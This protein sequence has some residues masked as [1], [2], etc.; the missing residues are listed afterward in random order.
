MLGSLLG[1]VS[2]GIEQARSLI[3]GQKPGDEGAEDL[4]DDEV[5]M[6]VEELG[7]DS[8]ESVVAPSSEPMPDVPG[9]APKTDRDEKLA[10]RVEKMMACLSLLGV[11]TL[12]EVAMDEDPDN[13]DALHALDQLLE[14]LDGLSKLLGEVIGTVDSVASL[15]EGDSDIAADA[16]TLWKE[17]EE[18]GIKPQ[19]L[20][21]LLCRI[22]KK[23]ST[24]ARA[25][26]KERDQI[27]IQNGHA[28]AGTLPRIDAPTWSAEQPLLGS[29]VPHHRYGASALGR[30]EASQGE[31]HAWQAQAVVSTCGGT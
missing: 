25:Q 16:Q 29:A 1:A 11:E 15:C 8:A 6:A 20:S 2:D 13:A 31:E 7:V 21:A 5:K 22:A 19:G 3:T 23:G 10:R 27:A 17:M 30:G 12:P 18:Q 24:A 28:A 26:G 9:G 14:K 4:A